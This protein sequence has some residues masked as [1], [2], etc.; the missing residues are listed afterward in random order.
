MPLDQPE[1][2]IRAVVEA[3][4][5]VTTVGCDRQSGRRRVNLTNQRGVAGCA[6]VGIDYQLRDLRMCI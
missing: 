6:R 1:D 4:G 5:N 3:D 2:L